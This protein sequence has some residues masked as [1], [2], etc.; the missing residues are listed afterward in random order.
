MIHEV[1]VVGA[2]QCNCSI[3][4]DEETREAIVIDPGDEVERILAILR[5]HNLKARYILNTH[6]HFDHVG[7]CCELKEVTGAEIWLHKADL[8][9]YESA[10][11]QAALFAMYG[12][13]PV[14]VT[15][16][17]QFL[18]DA[19]GLQV[20]KIATHAIH[21]PGHT[22]GS[23]SFHVPGSAR[24]LLF[25]GDTLFNGSIG[26]TDLPGG[27]FRQI[28]KSIRDRLFTFDDDTEV[29]PGHGPKTTIGWERR[30]NP[31]LQNL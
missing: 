30:T 17:D 11:R 3:L 10:P 22:P 4:G 24:N 2:L 7:N 28:L 6:A 29:W 5:K 12:V 15:A 25:A 1:L 23:L 13:K 26:R 27:D 21:T 19:D 18:Q 8:P 14:R 9:I 31:F 20:G 16:V